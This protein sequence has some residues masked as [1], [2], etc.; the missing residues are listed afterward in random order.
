MSWRDF[1]P[2]PTVAGAEASATAVAAEPSAASSR[3]QASTAARPALLEPESSAPQASPKIEKTCSLAPPR[4]PSKPGEL[5]P[6]QILEDGV[7]LVFVAHDFG[8]RTLAEVTGEP[9]VAYSRSPAQRW[10]AIRQA[11]QSVGFPLA[12]QAARNLP[13]SAHHRGENEH[14]RRFLEVECAMKDPEFLAGLYDGPN[15]GLASAI[16]ESLKT[17]TSPKSKM[18]EDSTSSNV[19]SVPGPPKASTTSTGMETGRVKG[20][21]ARPNPSFFKVQES[22]FDAH[23]LGL[24]ALAKLKRRSPRPTDR[25]TAENR[26]TVARAIREVGVEVARLAAR[27]LVLSADHRGDEALYMDIRQALSNPESFAA[28]FEGPDVEFDDALQESLKES[29]PEADD[30]QKER[31]R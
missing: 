20:T 7:E 31:S 11:I 9:F 14:G 28:L 29:A 5:S 12:R 4:S 25:K 23:D 10:R 18:E 1:K 6:A 15:D 21:V 19:S 17:S 26:R 3:P 22:V 24:R 27:N 2:T 30:E 13:L 16:R 8:M